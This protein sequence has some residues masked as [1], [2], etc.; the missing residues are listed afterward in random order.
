MTSI[1]H[2]KAE[3]RAVCRNGVITLFA[4]PGHFWKTIV[5]R[6]EESAL[7]WLGDHGLK[8]GKSRTLLDNAGLEKTLAE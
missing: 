5:V 6:S 7:Q 3:Y 4:K 2:R 8:R 1:H